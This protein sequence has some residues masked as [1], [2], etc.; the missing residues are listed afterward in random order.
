MPVAPNPMRNMLYNAVFRR[1][2]TYVAFTLTGAVVGDYVFQG[3][4]DGIWN[5]KNRGVYPPL[6]PASAQSSISA[7]TFG[8]CESGRAAAPHS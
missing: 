1:N 2:S 3:V 4:F 7:V 8:F 6:Q 5:M